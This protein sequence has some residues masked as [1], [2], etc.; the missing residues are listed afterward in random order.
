MLI[1][2][3]GIDSAVGCRISKDFQYVLLRGCKNVINQEAP[4][5]LQFKFIIYNNRS[6]SLKLPCSVFLPFPSFDLKIRRG[7]G[8]QD[9]FGYSTFQRPAVSS[10][11]HGKKVLSIVRCPVFCA[12][13]RVLFAFCMVFI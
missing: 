12:Y 9:C 3:V 13:G 4:P 6:L 5:I 11:V 7:E 8:E 2:L 1:V 10:S